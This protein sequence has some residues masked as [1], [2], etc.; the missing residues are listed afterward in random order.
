MQNLIPSVFIEN[1]YHYPILLLDETSMRGF[2][3]KSYDEGEKSNK[4]I[5][6]LL[7]STFEQLRD[8]DQTC[9]RV[10]R[11]DNIGEIYLM[12]H[13]MPFSKWD[14]KNIIAPSTK[15]QENTQFVIQRV[16]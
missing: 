8:F 1:E 15:T 12:N 16:D 3:F 14:T 2:D 6:L 5:H 10:S 7:C 11:W 4:V 9:G 13:L